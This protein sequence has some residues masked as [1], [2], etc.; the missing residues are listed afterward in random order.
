LI[1]YFTEKFG[2][3]A[4]R[5]TS[6]GWEA[7]SR[8]GPRCRES[9][10]AIIGARDPKGARLHLRRDRIAIKPGSKGIAEM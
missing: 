3:A 4:S 7:G 2:H 6:F 9:W 8:G 1:P 10:P 5:N